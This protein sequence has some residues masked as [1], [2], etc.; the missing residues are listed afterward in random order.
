MA[1]PLDIELLRE[2][3]VYNPYTGDFMWH[4]REAKHF[5]REARPL[6]PQQ[7]QNAADEWNER[8]AYTPALN[9]VGARGALT[10]IIMGRTVQAHTIA[11]AMH[12]GRMPSGQIDHFD[13]D[14]TH[15]AIFNLRDVDR[16]TAAV[17]RRMRGATGVAT[18]GV[19]PRKLWGL[20]WQYNEGTSDECQ[21]GM[22]V[23]HAP[24]V[25]AGADGVSR[26]TPVGPEPTSPHPH[27]YITNHHQAGAV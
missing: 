3:L 1:D 16:R 10:G 9:T 26:A 12:W 25:M 27:S 19:A 7:M 6:T 11:F 18:W 13:C 17:I 14:K 2:L 8:N 4:P 15:N 22:V 20:T 24:T 21:E 23:E 5:A